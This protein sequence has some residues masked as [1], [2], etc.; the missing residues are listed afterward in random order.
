MLQ[1]D[2]DDY[3]YMTISIHQE[4]FESSDLRWCA[5]KLELFYA[6]RICRREG[7]TSPLGYTPQESYLER[8]GNA[9]KIQ[10]EKH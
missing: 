9:G 2:W 4:L 7:K 5:K 10:W 8:H 6:Q 3:I 1:P